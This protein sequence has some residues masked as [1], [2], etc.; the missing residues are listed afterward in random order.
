MSE[1]KDQL[2]GMTPLRKAV[3]AL[4]RTQ[5]RLDAV[6]RR[7]V[8]P[9]ALVG[10]GCRL[11]GGVDSPDAYW[12]LLCEG[13]DVITQ[14]PPARWPTAVTQVD[15]GGRKIDI[16]RGGFLFGIDRFDYRFFGMTEQEA[17]QIDPQQRILL[18]VTWEALEDAGLVPE[19][20]RGAKCGVFLGIATTDYAINLA[21]DL[22]R[23]GPWL[24]PGTALCIAANRLSYQFDWHG[25]SLA[26]DTACSSSLLA[27]HLAVRSLR[28]GECDLAV[29]AGSNLLLSPFGSR[30]LA[31]A[32]FFSPSGRIRAFDRRADGYVRSDGIGVVVLKRQSDLRPGSDRSYARVLGTAVNQDGQSNG[33]TAP[34]RKRQEELLR[35]AC[36][37][38]KVTPSEV[39]YVETQG[40]GTPMGDSLEAA[41]LAAVY[42]EGRAAQEP[43]GIGSV[44]SNIG[45]TETASGVASVMKVAL[46][47]QHRTLPPSIHFRQPNPAIPF[48]DWKLKVQTELASWPQRMPPP[49]AGVS[50][51]GF[52]GTN[53][54]ALLEAAS[55][56]Q[57]R[58]RISHQ[59]PAA[60]PVLPASAALRSARVLDVLSS[61]PARPVGRVPCI[62][63]H[64]GP[65][66]TDP[67]EKCG[68]PGVAAA[69]PPLLL[70]SARS[71]AALRE[72]LERYL[73]LLAQGHHEWRD[74]CHSAA[75]HRQHH[76]WRLAVAAEDVPQA[77]ARLGGYLNGERHQWSQVGRCNPAQPAPIAFFFGGSPRAPGARTELLQSWGGV[78][79]EAL[80][81]CE[82]RM[83]RVL[84][85]AADHS[86]P[87]VGIE[88]RLRL[89]VGYRASAVAWRRLGV[90]PTRVAGI[91]I[92]AMAAAIEAGALDLDRV[93]R[94]L[95][96]GAP[97]LTLAAGTR[98]AVTL[99]LQG[100]EWK[101]GEPLDLSVQEEDG[102]T[103]RALHE[104]SP[105]GIVDVDHACLQRGGEREPPRP[106]DASAGDLL[107]R[108]L[109]ALYTRGARLDW[110]QIMHGRFVRLP[111]YPWQ[112]E[113]CWLEGGALGDGESTF[114]AEQE[115]ATPEEKVPGDAEGSARMHPRPDLYTP[116]EEPRTPLEKAIA[117]AW[118]EVL[119]IGP[120]G[121]HDHY[122]ELG[123]DSLQ[124]MMLLNWAQEA[125]QQTVHTGLLLQSMTVAE[126]AGNLRRE[127]PNEV[128]RAFPDEPGVE[129]AA[130]KG[131]G[132]LPLDPSAAGRSRREA[133][134]MELGEPVREL[135]QRPGCRDLPRA[136][137]GLIETVGPSPESRRAEELL[138]RLDDL[139]DEEVEQLLRQQMAEQETDVGP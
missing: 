139:S 128:L 3:L 110:M 117:Q 66:A 81:E 46:A 59:T 113:P 36:S 87:E 118:S 120:I 57:D 91:G 29:V 79:A 45:H 85:G 53:V 44:K 84:D 69:S 75:V 43:L 92:G 114:P 124:A 17:A 1:G 35:A 5:E 70:L 56:T 108:I 23:G 48:A 86:D 73:R 119:Q 94:E 12:R 97:T 50:A 26:L 95:T 24:G 106:G 78:F 25:P 62:H 32:G 80:A 68:L 13:R 67:G 40:T 89:L 121:L 28:D 133:P 109:G 64:L 82:S 138:G 130:E 123:G 51:F 99:V 102:A 127:Y 76:E 4:K 18:E 90:Q 101:G 65:L 122:L 19:R 54:H 22:L 55:D 33:L 42:G 60:E 6:Q 132:Q 104:L 137:Q 9:I 2:G 125:L 30:N 107:V 38:A 58:A 8:E 61:T 88:G 126:L 135:A 49:R 31:H 47:L 14:A 34:N 41:A 112:R 103:F 15:V 7:A 27:L 100:R 52:G 83:R 20:L 77:A 129:A 116:Y 71:E 98:P 37:A 39:D 74:L 96:V 115:M 21:R 105:N 136:P 131:P 111:T 63:G 11:P 72:L 93:L 10:L 134:E 16:G